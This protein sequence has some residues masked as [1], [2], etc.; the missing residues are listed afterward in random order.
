MIEPIP[1]PYPQQLPAEEALLLACA[2]SEMSPIEL[3]RARDLAPVVDWY[4]VERLAREHGVGSLV[5]PNLKLHFGH[6]APAE[7][8]DRLKRFSIATTQSNLG[9]LREVL[10]TVRE[11]NAH[12]IECAVFKGLLVNQLSYRNLA[13]RK[14]GD[15]DLL[16]RKRD[17]PRAKALFLSQ[18]FQQTLSDK[19]EL[20]CLQ[21]GLWHEERRLQIDLHWGIPPRELNIGADKIMDR[22]THVSIGSVKLPSFAMEDVLI[23]LCANAIK[24]FWNQLLYP[25]RDIAEFLRGDIALD[26]ESLFERARELKCGR[27]VAVAL[28]VVDALYEIPLPERVRRELR[29]EPDC[30]RVEQELLRQLF[31]RDTDDSIIINKNGHHLYY[32]DSP[33]SY[34]EALIDGA[35]KRLEYR[36]SVAVEPNEENRARLELTPASAL[37]HYLVKPFWMLGKLV[38]KPLRGRTDK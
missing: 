32:F 12:G 36:Y 37:L 21:S 24:E 17:Y 20:L 19:V 18:G 28:A 31:E 5:Y 23:I 10:S 11:L 7:I 34:Y 2:R 27:A 30:A 13:I 16:V 29:R 22:I 1:R 6:E 3:A 9:L 15:I 35:L 4:E 26:W 33:A 8:L 14:S 25:Y 38:L